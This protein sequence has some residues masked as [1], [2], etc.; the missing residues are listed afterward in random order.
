MESLVNHRRK[1]TID[2]AKNRFAELFLIGVPFLLFIIVFLIGF[3]CDSESF[4]NSDELFVFILFLIAQVAL[5]YFFTKYLSSFCDVQF[6]DGYVILTNMWGKVYQERYE[7][8]KGVKNIFMGAFSIQFTTK[9]KYLFT[10]SSNSTND[11]IQPLSI[12]TR[13]ILGK[14]VDKELDLYFRELMKQ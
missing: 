12:I 13:E 8:Y 6:R 14:S 10:Y 11:F 3:L 1:I 2:S 4:A 7:D 9:K 5:L